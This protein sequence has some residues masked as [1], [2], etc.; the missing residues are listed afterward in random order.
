MEKNEMKCASYGKLQIQKFRLFGVLAA[1]IMLLDISPVRAGAFA[2]ANPAQTE[3]SQ[4]KKVT[5]KVTDEKGETMPGVNVVVKGT[6]IG[7]VT[8]ADGVYSINVSKE[9]ASLTFSFVGYISKDVRIG[10]QSKIDVILSE[11]V[12]SVDEVVVVGYGTQKKR[13]ITGAITSVDEKM[14]EKTSGCNRI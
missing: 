14:I 9:N 8:N 4:E 5:G 1:L 3:V 11:D 2:K 12:Q 7:A 13:D 10:N 6:T